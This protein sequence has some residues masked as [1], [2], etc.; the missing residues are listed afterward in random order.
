M[1][2]FIVAGTLILF[3]LKIT[4]E[5]LTNCFLSWTE[6]AIIAAFALFVYLLFIFAVEI[7]KKKYLGKYFAGALV[8][9]FWTL[10]AL[11]CDSSR[12]VV[13]SGYVIFLMSI[14]FFKNYRAIL[15][16]GLLA[17]LGYSFLFVFSSD[18]GFTLSTDVL[19]ISLSVL[20]MTLITKNLQEYFLNLLNSQDYIE[21]ER[22]T[23]EIKVA[24]RTKELKE[25]AL[26]LEENVK[27]RTKELQEK[28]DELEKFQK[29]I[30]G[31]EL[32]MVELKSEIKRLNEELTNCKKSKTKKSNG[33]E[34]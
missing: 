20:L 3:L 31:R 33:T 6:F 7:K 4:T 1:V 16:S 34:R 8:V 9:I 11:F 28:I 30:I 26:S 15:F 17:L 32:K 24:A 10:V 2:V 14:S 23:L 12:E 25:L 22:M 18:K 29:L 21:E 19:I 5:F 27:T 13:V